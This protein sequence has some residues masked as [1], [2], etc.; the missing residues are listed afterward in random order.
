MTQ[1]PIK[2]KSVNYINLNSSIKRTSTD[3]NNNNSL[4]LSVKKIYKRSSIVIP[5]RFKKI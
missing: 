1:F 3:L 2:G 4:G 5:S